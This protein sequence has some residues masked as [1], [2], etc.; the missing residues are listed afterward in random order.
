MSSLGKYIDDTSRYDLHYPT[1]IK[2]EVNKYVMSMDSAGK[3]KLFFINIFAGNED[4]CLSLDQLEGVITKMRHFYDDI[5]IVLLDP[6]GRLSHKAF[7]GIYTAKFSTIH[8]AMALIAQ[9]DLVISPDTA[10]VHIAA[11]YNTPLVAIYQDIKLNNNLWAPGYPEATQILSKKGKLHQNDDLQELIVQAAG[12][13][14]NAAPCRD[15]VV[16]G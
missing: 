1:K 4:R 10:I 2:Q 15:V 7:E 12:I 8:H 11:A 3:K 13:K 9:C 16:E 5:N 14:L 6:E